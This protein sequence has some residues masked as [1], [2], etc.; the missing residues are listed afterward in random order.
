MPYLFHHE[1]RR[2]HHQ[3]HLYH[4]WAHLCLCRRL[5]VLLSV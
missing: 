4:P 2:A 1:N 3:N 5:R